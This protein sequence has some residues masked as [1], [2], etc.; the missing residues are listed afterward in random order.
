MIKQGKFYGEI[1]EGKLVLDSKTVFNVWIEN[2]EGQ[3]VEITVAKEAE[4]ITQQQ[5]AYLFA[6]VY[7]PL[8]EHTGHTVEEID[9]ILKKKFLTKNKGK[10]TEYVK[11]KSR[12]TKAE[13]AKYIDDCIMTAAKTGVVVLPPNKFKMGD[14]K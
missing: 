13:L 5:W 12:L 8:S 1:K 2:W 11:D 14:K 6:C 7:A 9:G 10:K 3:R 4:N